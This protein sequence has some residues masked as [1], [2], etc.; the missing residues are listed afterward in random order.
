MT[1]KKTHRELRNEITA[2]ITSVSLIHP[3]GIGWDY[4][5]TEAT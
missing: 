5:A 1:Q 4:L 2:I 3:T